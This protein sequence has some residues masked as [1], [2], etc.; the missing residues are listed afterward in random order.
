MRR[1]A[2]ALGLVLTAALVPAL[3][4]AHRANIDAC[5]T[6]A[7]VAF[8]DDIF[9]Y[10]YGDRVIL[11]GRVSSHHDEA[12]VQRMAPGSDRWERV[13]TVSISD[14]GRMKWRWR[15]HRR[16]AV[17]DAPYLLRFKI[18]GHGRSDT[19]QAFILFGE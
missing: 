16:D 9:S 14:A 5:L 19:V 8:C 15:T 7:D 6:R 12:V 17:Q 13:G 3:A 2:L 18:P 1:I 11:K 10:L 4:T